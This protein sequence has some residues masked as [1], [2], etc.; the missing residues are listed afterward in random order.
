[1]TT[2]NPKYEDHSDARVL[3]I[4]ISRKYYRELFNAFFDKS[5]C[6]VYTHKKKKNKI[7]KHSSL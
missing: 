7:K 3:F 2:K 1:M 5:W 4:L 6:T